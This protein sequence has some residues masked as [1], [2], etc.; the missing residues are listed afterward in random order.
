[1]SQ[2]MPGEFLQQ[3]RRVMAKTNTN[4]NSGLGLGLFYQPDSL[5]DC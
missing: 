2:L 5:M 4:L 1:M 3:F